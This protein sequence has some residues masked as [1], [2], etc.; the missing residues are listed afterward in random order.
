[1]K[2]PLFGLNENGPG[3]QKFEWPAEKQYKS[4]HL[5]P[6][7]EFTLETVRYKE[8]FGCLKAIGLTTNGR[9][10]RKTPLFEAGRPDRMPVSSVLLDT[11]MKVTTI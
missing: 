4:I 6:G 9:P 2:T 5:H 3:L 10:P 7:E 8:S 1:M 11:T